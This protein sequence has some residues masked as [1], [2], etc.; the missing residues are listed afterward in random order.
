MRDFLNVSALLVLIGAATTAWAT[1]WFRTPRKKRIRE[2]LVF[3]GTAI[4]I[5]GAFWASSQ[6]A[7][8]EREV[9]E[10]T[11]T[12]L[13][14][15]T[16]ADSYC[17]VKAGGIDINPQRWELSMWHVGNHACYDVVVNVKDVDAYKA[18]QAPKSLV[19]LQPALALVPLGTVPAT[20]IKPIFREI[21]L[22]GRTERRFS[23]LISLRNGWVEQK[24]ALRK[25]PVDVTKGQAKWTKASHVT[26]HL[27]GKPVKDFDDDTDP[28][29]PRLPSGEIQW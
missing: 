7:A 15:V 22:E 26:V 5:A 8:H 24:L 13:A 4:S 16:G 2:A 1:F 25:V 12:V 10:L 29:F 11:N 20:D 9:T 3:I 23:F 18:V 6:K 17:Y 27:T 14:N 21:N 28:L 19:D